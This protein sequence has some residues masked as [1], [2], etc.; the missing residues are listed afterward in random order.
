MFLFNV[1]VRSKANSVKMWFQKKKV[2]NIYL[3]PEPLPIPNANLA[4]L[5]VT[6]K[7]AWEHYAAATEVSEK[8]EKVSVGRLRRVIGAETRT[9]FLVFK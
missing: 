8:S 1:D 6:F 7:K 3:A 2:A 9:V 4:E 5:W